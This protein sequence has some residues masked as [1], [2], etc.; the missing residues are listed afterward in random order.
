DR[1]VACLES[2]I[3]AARGIPNAPA[4]GQAIV[5]VDS[6]STDESVPRALHPLQG[7]GMPACNIACS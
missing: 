2:L 7:L 5:Y 1:L 4:D 6:G 3:A